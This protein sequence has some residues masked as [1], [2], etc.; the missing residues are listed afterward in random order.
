MRIHPS[1]VAW[2]GILTF[3][4]SMFVSASVLPVQKSEALTRCYKVDPYWRNVILNG[5][6]C[7]GA[8]SIDNSITDIN[9]GAFQNNSTITSVS[10]Q[11]FSAIH[12]NAFQNN[13]SLQTVNLDY[14]MWAISNYAF[15][16]DPNLHSILIP[17]TFSSLPAEVFDQTPLTSIIYCGSDNTIKSTLYGSNSISTTCPQGPTDP[18]IT[19]SDQDYRYDTSTS[20]GSL[21]CAEGG[22]VTVQRGM[23]T[24]VNYLCVGTFTLPAGISGLT[25]SDYIQKTPVPGS[26][27]A[28]YLYDSLH[29]FGSV[30]C[31]GS[32]YIS[33]YNFATGNSHSCQGSVDIPANVT[34]IS[35]ATFANKT[36]I[37]ISAIP[38]SL[39]TIAYGAFVGSSADISSFI[40]PADTFTL[41]NQDIQLYFRSTGNGKLPCLQSGG[42]VV[43]DGVATDGSDCQGTIY[44]PVGVIAG[45][46]SHFWGS[47]RH[48]AD[49]IGDPTGNT[50]YIYDSEYAAG[51]VTCSAGGIV[52]FSRGYLITNSSCAGTLDIPEP[53]N[54][55]L[56][57]SVLGGD[58]LLTSIRFPSTFL[59]IPES[60]PAGQFGNLTGLETITVADGNPN[61]ASVDGVL[62]TQ[63]LQS[64]LWYPKKKLNATYSVPSTVNALN[65]AAFS[66]NQYLKSLSIPESVISIDI[67]V[68]NNLSGLETITVAEDNPNYSSI[69]GVLLTKDKQ[70]IL[71]YPLMKSDRNY[72]IPPT[73]TAVGNGTF[74]ERLVSSVSIPRSVTSIGESAFAY[75]SNLKTVTFE[76]NSTLETISVSAFQ[77]TS[78]KKIIIP[79]S[80]TNIGYG[81]FQLDR[82][83]TKVEFESGSSLIALGDNVFSTTSISSIYIPDG[84]QSIPNGTF[85]YCRNLVYVDLGT[86][87]QLLS[88][89][90][91]AF[92]NS[93][94]LKSIKFPAGLVSIGPNAFDGTKL[95]DITFQ[96][97]AIRS[98]DKPFQAVDGVPPS[99]WVQDT[100]TA[101]LFGGPGLNGDGI[102][103]RVG[104]G[105]GIPAPVIASPKA[106]STYLAMVGKPF[107]LNMNYFAQSPST[108]SISSG[109]LP[110]GLT[111]DS[112]GNITGIPTKAND[113][114][115]SLNVS[116]DVAGGTASVNNLHI[117]VTPENDYMISTNKRILSY[118]D[119]EIAQ[120]TTN[121]P[122]DFKIGYFFWDYV[123]GPEFVDSGFNTVGTDLFLQT[124]LQARYNDYCGSSVAYRLRIYPPETSYP[125][126]STPYLAEV[127]VA[128]SNGQSTPRI[129]APLS[130]E[131]IAFKVGV[132]LEDYRISFLPGTGSNTVTASAALPAGL[133]LHS[134]GS[135]TGAP[136]SPGTTS[137][138]F[139]V[140]DDAGNSATATSVQFVISLTGN[141]PPSDNSHQQQNIVS[142]PAPDP[143]QQSKISSISPEQVIAGTATTLTLSGTFIEKVG[144]IQLN[145]SSIAPGTWT[146]SP[147]SI[148][149]RLPAMAA[150][151]Y[152]IQLFNGAAPVLAT[153]LSV[154][155]ADAVTAPVTPSVDTSTVT[156]INTKQTDTSTAAQAKPSTPV[157]AISPSSK[158]TV[159]PKLSSIKKPVA[160]QT[161]PTA[162]SITIVCVHGKS[163]KAIRGVLPKCPAGFVKK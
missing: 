118:A 135:I 158:T 153:Q 128:A 30:I 67:G 85:Q 156:S 147:I 110:D 52:T 114:S 36:G 13:S 9:A 15:S 143:V 95:S 47:I 112:Q 37:T 87:S 145:G 90:G 111:L 35:A 8:I 27:G 105:P 64:I 57:D 45:N 163:A 62:L 19:H 11:W 70:T 26:P 98:F 93:D 107:T 101:T 59:G 150:G 3:L 75:N 113:F 63:D 157:P 104:G 99:G 43:I 55:A 5:S 102:N 103:I 131:T 31:S 91:T 38:N 68:L 69:D 140:T 86:G 20:T 48:S 100:A 22:S 72:S 61:F 76:S 123:C 4:F 144:V 77:E 159:I 10:I 106:G 136:T 54:F 39:N 17:S 49:L 80:V 154:A 66:Q 146:Q 23:V 42:L 162:K 51:T 24:S 148:S 32:G 138:D 124:G 65:S 116:E 18:V 78:L 1:K 125:D 92:Y 82:L 155:K 127:V 120:I 129:V 142:T 126:L 161:R 6:S 79:R 89:G 25:W 29:G 121:A 108:T 152:S 97:T 60:N 50:Y 44:V 149:F 151:T 12:E 41:A 137:V 40:G 115:F 94:S 160:S 122:D 73:V 109:S 96:G 71:Y 58:S 7:G 56:L 81:A 117:K 134:D 46:P 119:N 130:S 132:P 21:A 139:T 28:F 141:S 16:N 34:T 133:T 83:L 74:A 53:F 14:G 2:L 88:I 84:V 33:I